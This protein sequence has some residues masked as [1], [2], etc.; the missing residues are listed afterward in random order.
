MQVNK[1]F[2]ILLLIIFPVIAYWN[3]FDVPFQFDDHHVIRDNPGIR[4]LSN[5][6][7]VFKSFPHRPVAQLTFALNYH[8]HELDVWG[9]HLVNLV[10]HI[11]N[12]LLVFWLVLQILHRLKEKNSIQLKDS[13]ILFIAFS[14]GLLFAVHP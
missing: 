13:E 3:S 14:T 5:L 11:I 10:I 9:Y 12:A 8:F 2:F 1:S 7:K 6:E 4:D